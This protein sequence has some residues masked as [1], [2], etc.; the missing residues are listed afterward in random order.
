MEKLLPILLQDELS[1]CKSPF[2]LIV[3]NVVL[4]LECQKCNHSTHS[5]QILLISFYG[6]FKWNNHAV[7]DIITAAPVK[8]EIVLSVHNHQAPRQENQY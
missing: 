6:I 7:E 1:T 8:E 5:F 3:D 4:I 2:R